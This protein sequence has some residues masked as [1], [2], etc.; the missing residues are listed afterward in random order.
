MEQGNENNRGEENNHRRTLCISIKVGIGIVIGGVALRLLRIAVTQY[1]PQ[2]LV[3]AAVELV[4]FPALSALN[5][6][7]KAVMRL[8]MPCTLKPSNIYITMINQRFSSSIY[9]L[10]L[11]GRYSSFVIYP[12]YSNYSNY[13][14]RY[15]YYMVW[16]IIVRRIMPSMTKCHWSKLFI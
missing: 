16:I 1:L 11:R 2:G 7:L 8:P 6:S 14:C 3:H 9:S 4:L 12:C 13:L 10:P 15:R 5:N